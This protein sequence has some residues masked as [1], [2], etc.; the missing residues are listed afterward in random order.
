LSRAKREKEI[1]A[2]APLG[3]QSAPDPCKPVKLKDGAT[4]YGTKDAALIFLPGGRVRVIRS[5]RSL[6]HDWKNQT[7][8]LH[9]VEGTIESGA[10]LNP[11]VFDLANCSSIENT[12]NLM[13]AL[14][15]IVS[16]SDESAHRLLKEFCAM[17]KAARRI[18]GTSKEAIPHN[19]YF[20]RKLIELA[21]TLQ[22]PPTKGE[23]AKA[24]NLQDNKAEVSR[25][26]RETRFDWLP[27]DTPGPT[28]RRRRSRN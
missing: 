15:K 28:A 16:A 10:P 18:R 1:K 14:Q 25:L 4:R 7:K 20:I 3:V 27:R 23:L 26:C 12:N 6:S 19:R 11:I 9:A 21:K 17:I 24:L 22:R 8:G 2:V 5:A 13:S